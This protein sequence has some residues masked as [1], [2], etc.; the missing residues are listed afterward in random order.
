MNHASIFPLVRYL[1]SLATPLLLRLPVSAN[2]VTA[3]SLAT[4]LLSAL[5]L[6]WNEEV[7][8]ALL[9]I[10]TYVLDNCD[11]E[12]ARTKNQCS[13]FGRRFDTIVDWIVHSAF[14]LGLGY[15]VAHQNQSEIW[16]WMGYAAAIGG[17]INYVIGLY[18]EKADAA[19]KVETQQPHHQPQGLVEWTV[20][21]F[22]ELTRADFCF[23]VLLLALA[24]G[25]WL[26]LPAGAIGAQVYWG[27]QFLSFA[28]RFH[29]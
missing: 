6:A 3:A 21:I 1:S 18:F 23:L 13:E 11:G 24:N 17:T 8:G 22:R 7:L 29:V 28:R 4:G 26:L 14:F 10:V 15:G 16:A 9:L 5:A 2:Q 12:V 19:E 25:T 27:L 20:F